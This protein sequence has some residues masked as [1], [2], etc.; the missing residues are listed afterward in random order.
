MVVRKADYAYKKSALRF[1]LK[2]PLAAKVFC[3]ILEEPRGI[4]NTAIAEKLEFSD[5]GGV[6]GYLKVLLTAG[7][8][9]KANKDGVMQPYKAKSTD[10]L[11]EQI[12]EINKKST[13]K[14]IL[15]IKKVNK[16]YG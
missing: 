10:F 6:Q 12:L 2:N 15:L 11:N 3:I 1:A 13:L 9:E 5:I 16:R 4:T 8:I 14:E 7:L